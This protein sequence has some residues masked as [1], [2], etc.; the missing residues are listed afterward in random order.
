M[1]KETQEIR[2]NGAGEEQV[3]I[4]MIISRDY[5]AHVQTIKIV[6]SEVWET[7][8][9]EEAIAKGTRKTWNEFV[10]ANPRMSIEEASNAYLKLIEGQSPWPENFLPEQKVLKT[11]DTFQMA[12][13]SMQPVS[14]PGSF[15]TL[16]NII[17]VNYVRN[18]LAVKSDWKVDC[19]KVV[20]YRV[21]EG[22]ELVVLK[23][24]VG[25]QIDINADKYLPGGGIQIQMFFD[26]SADKMDYLE[27]VLVRSIN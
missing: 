25:P 5:S 24:I 12:L 1:K 9:I 18:N 4:L 10:V 8:A 11:G 2:V 6:P 21:K 19:S 7:E 14:S 15:A 20:T 23:G 26:G 3:L 27:V 16:D 17:N 22:I 13:D